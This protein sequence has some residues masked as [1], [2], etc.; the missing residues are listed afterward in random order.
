MFDFLIRVASLAVVAGAGWIGGSIYPAPEQVTRAINAPALEQRAIARLREVD[1]DALRARL[2]EEDFAVISQRAVSAATQAGALIEVERVDI[3]TSDYAPADVAAD[4]LPAS[5]SAPAVTTAPV[6]PQAPT[7]P[8]AALATTPA[9]FES[10]LSICPGMSVSNA[11]ATNAQRAVVNY[12]P[13][14]NVGGVA[15]AANPTRGACLSSGYGPRRSRTHHG[16]D[17]HAAVGGPILAAGDGTVLEL[18][19]RDDY[20]NMVLID[21]G[22]GVYTRYAHLSSFQQGL[23]V[24]SRV[25]AGEQ[26]GLMG[27]TAGYPLPIHLHYE[28]LQGDYN[29]PRQSFGLAAANPFGFAAP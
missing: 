26:I 1:W 14:V 27:N 25:R 5:V 19:Y 28:V 11:P 22:A 20:G 17:Y 21:H 2:P 24:G 4:F 9:A 7:A 6:A 12:A 3:A 10:A 29:T 15:L 18:K 16:V 13:V 8:G 23:A